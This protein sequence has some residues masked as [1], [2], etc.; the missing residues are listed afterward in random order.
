VRIYFLRAR[1]R[2]PYF[3]QPLCDIKKRNPCD[4]R[5]FR[6]RWRAPSKRCKGSYKKNDAPR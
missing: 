3:L 6:H 5:T 4:I 2:N 1:T